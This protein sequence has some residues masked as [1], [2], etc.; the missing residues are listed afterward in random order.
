MVTWLGL[1]RVP[2]K[3][4]FNKVVEFTDGGATMDVKLPTEASKEKVNVSPGEIESGTVLTQNTVRAV[5]EAWPARNAVGLALK[6]TF[7]PVWERTATG[8][9]SR[10]TIVS[11]NKVSLNKVSLNKVS[12]N[13]PLSVAI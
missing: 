5:F 7:D 3:S 13:K 2:A 8:S 12:L 1:E 6:A 9:S 10:M 4:P 11:L